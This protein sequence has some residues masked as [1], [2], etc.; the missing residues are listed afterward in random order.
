VDY[1]PRF[2]KEWTLTREAFDKLLLCL[3]TDRELAAGK[4]EQIRKRLITFFEC[5]GSLYPEDHCD[6]TI[7]RVARKI[8]E[9]Q[10]IYTSNP[11]GFFF[12]VARKILQESW[13]KRPKGEV[14][15]D[16]SV[17]AALLS[18]D[19][20]EALEQEAQHLEFEHG[21]ACLER[22]LRTLSDKDKET[23]TRYYQGE[24]RT[25]IKNR[26]RLAEE[27]GVALNALRIRA[28]RIRQK[29]ESC[30]NKC[31]GRPTAS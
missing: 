28:L 27:L 17:D 19:P 1:T 24:T 29:L 15:L 2:K 13:D 26:K 10:E 18:Q 8:S 11:I 6:I 16:H 20:A 7:N 21:M 4:Y 25:K 23:I 12:G 14:P 31:M 5:R 30:V 9:G 22:C 3:D